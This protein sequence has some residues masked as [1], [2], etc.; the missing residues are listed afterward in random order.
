MAFVGKTNVI[1]SM[2]AAFVGVLVNR[3]IWRRS[4]GSG[5]SRRWFKYYCCDL[6][7]TG[8]GFL[9]GRTNT[10]SLVDGGLCD[11]ILVENIWVDHFTKENDTK[12]G[13]RL[14]LFMHRKKHRLPSNQLSMR[15]PSAQVPS[16]DRHSPTNDKRGKLSSNIRLGITEFFIIGSNS[17]W[18]S[19]SSTLAWALFW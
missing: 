16:K 7:S 15:I 17:R 14:M 12:R 18:S 5:E 13:H 8:W 10:R 19:F 11:V 2:E 3:N 1:L 6:W 4:F 9:R